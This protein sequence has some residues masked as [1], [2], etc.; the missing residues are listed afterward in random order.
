MF[1]VAILEDDEDIPSL[2]KG[3]PGVLH[4]PVDN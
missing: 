4:I 1:D 2:L 3:L